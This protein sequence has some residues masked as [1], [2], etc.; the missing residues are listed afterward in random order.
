MA[1]NANGT[2][3]PVGMASRAVLLSAGDSLSRER[4]F[5]QLGQAIR[6][7]GADRL[8]KSVVV[9]KSTLIFRVMPTLHMSEICDCLCQAD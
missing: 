7:H 5:R 1:E 4:N 9:K 6:I 2:S 8:P 3:P